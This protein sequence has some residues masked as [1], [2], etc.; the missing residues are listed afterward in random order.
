MTIKYC[1]A[2][3]QPIAGRIDKKFCDASCRSSYHN[4]SRFNSD[5]EPV[6]RNINNILKRNRRILKELLEDWEKTAVVVDKQYLIEQG[7][8]FNYFTE[9]YWNDKLE[10]YFYCYDYGYR[11]LEG[12]KVMAVKDTRR[13]HKMRRNEQSWL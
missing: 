7:F 6:I 10:M 4:S 3:K 12:G 1:L 13:T 2:C 11:K 5:V 8:H 9:Q